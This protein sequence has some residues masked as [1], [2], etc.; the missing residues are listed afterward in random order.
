MHV[1]CHHIKQVLINL[2]IIF[3]HKRLGFLLIGVNF[4]II[5]S[6]KM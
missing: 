2:K 3:I 1:T 6:V 5:F 4:I